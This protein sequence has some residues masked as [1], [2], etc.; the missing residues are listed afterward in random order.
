MKFKVPETTTFLDERRVEVR[1]KS[2]R[3]ENKKEGI[4]MSVSR[5]FA[6]HTS[7]HA[8]YKHAW[9]SSDMNCWGSTSIK[10]HDLHETLC[11]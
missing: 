9:G 3:L 1:E 6:K 5:Q 7:V 10:K 8:L 11:S 4:A 2:P